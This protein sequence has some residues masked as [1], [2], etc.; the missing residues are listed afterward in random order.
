MAARRLAPVLAEMLAAIEGIET[1]TAGKSLSDF[2]A[3]WLLRHA[4]Q[5]ALE[6]ISEAARHIPDD[7]LSEA[8]TIPWKQIR[9]VRNILRHEYHR[10]ADDVVWA[11]VTDHIPALRR[12]IE[13]L[14]AASHD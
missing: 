5:R 4:V 10:V 12:A 14:A 11:V 9:G 2:Q 13:A 8:P 7:R 3:D 6:I 1:H